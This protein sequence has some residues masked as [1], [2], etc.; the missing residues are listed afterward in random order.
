MTLSFAKFGVD[1]TD[2][3]TNC[4]TKWPHFLAILYMYAVKADNAVILT[5]DP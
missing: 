4:K 3:Y 5:N 1:I 2:F